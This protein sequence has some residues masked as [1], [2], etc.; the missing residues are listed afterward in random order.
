MAKV[1]NTGVLFVQKIPKKVKAGFKAWCAEH[2]I[3]MTDALTAI[4]RG[5]TNHHSSVLVSIINERKR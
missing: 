3:T 4:L 1:D 2:G 5:T